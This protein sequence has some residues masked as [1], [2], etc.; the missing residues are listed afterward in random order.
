MKQKVLQVKNKVPCQFSKKGIENWIFYMVFVF[1]GTKIIGAKSMK[2]MVAT[3]KKP[4]RVMM[5]VKAGP[6]VDDFIETLVSICYQAKAVS[7][8]VRIVSENSEHKLVIK[9]T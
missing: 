6:A 1:S 9:D 5:L 8:A 4:R 7:T 2:E 3:L